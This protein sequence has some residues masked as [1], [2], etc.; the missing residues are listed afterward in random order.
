MLFYDLI[1]CILVTM[2]P[3]REPAFD[4]AELYG[5]IPKDMKKAVDVRL[6]RFLFLFFS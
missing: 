3:P 1:M 2:A 4:P 6:V 5:I